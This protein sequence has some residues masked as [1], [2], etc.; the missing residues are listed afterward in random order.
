[1]SGRKEW[2]QDELRQ[3]SEGIKEI[4]REIEKKAQN[5]SDQRN[6]STLVIAAILEKHDDRKKDYRKA[7]PKVSVKDEGEKKVVEKKY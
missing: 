2:E 6:K 1:M 4:Q 7:E 3:F 5:G